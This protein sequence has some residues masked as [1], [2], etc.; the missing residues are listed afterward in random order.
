VAT[1]DAGGASRFVFVLGTGRCGS[2]LVEEVLC[3]HPSVGFV[4]NLEDRFD[5]PLSAS[6]WNGSLYRRLPAA[7]TQKSRLRYAPSEAYRV[8]SRDV[9]PLLVSP[10]RDLLAGDVTPWLEGRFRAF[11]TERAAAQSTDTFLHKFT[12]WP[13]SGFIRGVFPSARF[14]HVVRDGRAVANSWLQ[15]PWWLGYEGPDHWQ[16]GPLPADL[17]AEWNESGQSFVVLA[18]LLW[19]MLID[20]FDVARKEIP[21][22]DWLEVRYEDVAANPRATFAKM[23]EFCGLPWDAEF[24][25]GFER[26]TFT[27][28][29]SDA[30]RRD[31]AAADVDRLSRILASSLATRR[32][33]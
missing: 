24:E 8:L 22:A 10:P 1:P 15:M 16:W 14:I 4:S 3:R 11:F 13:R 7:V 30:F 31:L 9:S 27:A 5:L 32:Y 21:A 26:H 6:R 23:L 18:G 33:V 19:K 12:G 17:A 28:S 29:R 2:T 25:R 20:A